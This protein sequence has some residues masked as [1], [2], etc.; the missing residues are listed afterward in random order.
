[1]CAAANDNYRV[2]E[3]HNQ[4]IISGVGLFIT[5]GG[6]FLWN[7]FLSRVYAENSGPY[8]VR[9]AFLHNFGDTWTW[10]LTV[11]ATLAGAL[12]LELLVMAIRRVYFP[13]D[14]DLMQEIEH[15]DTVMA[16]TNEHAAESGEAGG[17]KRSETDGVTLITRQTGFSIS[18]SLAPLDEKDELENTEMTSAV[19]SRERW[20][21]G[22]IAREPEIL[23]R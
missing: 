19:V 3:L 18:P 13:T 7:I 2:L 23:S 11:M 21:A 14:Q 20:T 16:A 22:P 6:W 1:M 17:V 15:C 5:V 4:T 9:N 12:A 10:W 8:L